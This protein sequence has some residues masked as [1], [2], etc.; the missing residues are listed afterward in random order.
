MSERPI[1]SISIALAACIILAGP[2]L[3][4]DETRVPVVVDD[5][6]CEPTAIEV[7]S[8]VVV[9]EV[10]NAGG[11]IGEFEI[12]SGDRVVDEVENIVPGFVVNMVTRLDGGSYETVCYTLVSP[13]G[14]LEVVGGTAP[15]APPSDVVDAAV[16]SAARDDYK[17][18]VDER[19]TAL[20]QDVGAFVAAI[21]AGDLD[22]A[23]ALYAPSRVAWEEIEPIAELYADLDVAIDAREEDF[24]AGVDDPEFTGFHRIER[25]LW[26]EGASGDLAS[27]GPEAGGGRPR[28][29]GS[30]RRAR[31]RAA[32]HGS[33]GRRAH[34]R[35]RAVQ[36]DGRGG[37]LLARPT[38]GRSAP[39]STGRDG[40]S[41][42]C[43]PSSSR[44]TQRT[45]G[46][47]TQPSGTSRQSSTSTATVTASRPS[48][49][50]APTT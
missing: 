12:L 18:W 17:A 31:H 32:R 30:P 9:F 22:A 41:T 42:S 13:R 5:T 34:R 39:T 21:V 8:G 35:G 33:R 50:S 44:S 24:A 20:T 11:D 46:R 4:Q 1:R 29:R 38:S 48:V 36:A 27:P 19:A 49:T 47:W 28:P 23:R 6:G 7:P 37:P 15:S 3:A 45:W 10:T 25:I 26:V 43:G 40:S 14:T 16:L 2:V